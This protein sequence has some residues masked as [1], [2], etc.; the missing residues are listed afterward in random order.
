MNKEDLVRKWL[1]DE[2]TATESEA[3]TALDDHDMHIKIIES[4]QLF[5]ASEVSEIASLDTIYKKAK[6]TN[7]SGKNW[8]NQF[9][10]IAAIFVVLLGVGSLFF[11]NSDSNIDTLAGEKISIELPDASAVMLNSKSEIV[12]NKPNWKDKRAVTLKGEA[13]FKVTKGS[14]FDVITETGTVSV[15]GTQFNVK[16]RKGYFEVQCFEGLVNVRYNGSTKNLSAGTTFKVINGTISSDA[17]LD[18]EPQWINNISSFKS[19]PFQEVIKEFE[20][21]YDVVF[22]LENID[23]SRIFTGGFVHSNLEDA[24][25]SITLPLDL[26]YKIDSEKHITLYNKQ[27]K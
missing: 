17:T 11:L 18:I 22:S 24:L 25:K 6:Q 27:S 14:T 9:L 21:Q 2:L 8:Y 16:S 13:F 12:F 5:K 10:K 3:F 26:E 20:R 19:V 4:A 1:V 23:T 7:N 15:L